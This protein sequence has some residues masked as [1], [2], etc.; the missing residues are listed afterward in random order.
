MCKT[1][2][3]MKSHKNKENPMKKKT[4]NF[5]KA[6]FSTS[7]NS[8]YVLPTHLHMCI[9][10]QVHFLFRIVF[11]AG[12]MEQTVQVL[13]YWRTE[14]KKSLIPSTEPNFF[15]NLHI[16]LLYFL[17]V[18]SLSRISLFFLAK[19]QTEGV[20]YSLLHVMIVLF[21]FLNYPFKEVQPINGHQKDHKIIK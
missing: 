6:T 1:T 15:L 8:V 12:A 17:H 7:A 19:A 20:T 13:L 3:N 9:E 5:T 18:L 21:V 14:L 4:I 2:M 11:N 10:C 16:C